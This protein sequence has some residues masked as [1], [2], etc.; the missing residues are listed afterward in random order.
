M[1]IQFYKIV[2]PTILSFVDATGPIPLPLNTE[3]KVA[4]VTPSVEAGQDLKIDYTLNIVAS[5]TGNWSIAFETRLY[6]DNTLINT[7]TYSRNGSQTG[8]QFIP[9]S[10]TYVDT[11]P[12][13]AASSVYDL[14]AII[15]SATSATA[16][17]G[18]NINMNIITFA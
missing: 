16:K 8:D 18:T 14:K 3:V 11:A 5:T 1:G 2:S 4:T 15:T 17:T 7:R 9:M 13:S 10:S 6:R 12:V